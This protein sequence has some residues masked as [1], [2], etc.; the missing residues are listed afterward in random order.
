MTTVYLDHSATTPV[1]PEV[2]DAMLPFL[3]DA[4]G[5]A[6]SIH[7]FGRAA[8][9]AVDDARDQVAAL[10]HADPREIVL[11]SG[12]TESNNL[13]IRG[14]VAA[15][16]PGRRRIVVSAVEHHAVLHA[17]EYV[18]ANDGVELVVVGVD[19]MGRVDSD[20]IAAAVDDA[21]VLVSV[22]HGNNETGTIQP[23]EAIARRCAER[24]VPFHCDAVQSVG[25]VPID[26]DA[27]PVSMLSISGH[28]LGAPKGVGAL[29]IR[30]GVS[31]AAQ[32]VG[33]GQE[34]GRRAGTE[35]VAGIVALGKACEMARTEMGE[36]SARMAQLRDVL[37]RGILNCIPQAQVNGSQSHRLPHILNVGF[38]GADGESLVLAFDSLGIAVSSGSA[39]T[40]GS[41]DPSHVLLAMGLSYGRAQSAVRFSL[42]TTT[43]PA[44]IESVVARTPDV[45]RRCSARSH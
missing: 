12:G 31:I 44:E 37:E 36:A 15:V 18:R 45:V 38:P 21:T 41:L 39:C 13:A 43:T 22:M 25:K 32:A 28:K 30:N 40:A 35:N 7:A 4:Y 33:G 5:N 19:S 20:E 23:V 14:A 3:R 29:Y 34:R 1:R 17:A 27:W 9:R 10:L 26:V 2:L 16:A 6:G 8:R 42:G 11:T 24:G